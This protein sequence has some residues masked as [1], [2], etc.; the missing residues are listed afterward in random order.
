MSSGR[1]PQ[2]P[3]CHWAERRRETPGQGN[4]KRCITTRELPS[5]RPA[6]WKGR[7]QH[8]EVS[9]APPLRLGADGGT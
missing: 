2:K 1:T 4:T 7:N 3:R 5:K 6:K 8:P 9:A